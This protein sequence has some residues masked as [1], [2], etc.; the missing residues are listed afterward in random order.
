MAARQ[1][2][3]NQVIAKQENVSLIKSLIYKVGPIS[4]AEISEQL[5][6]TPPTI[7]NI[8]AEMIRDGI[9]QELE[10]EKKAP[11]GHA[12]R[13]PIRIDFIPDSRLAL[14]ISLGRDYTHYCISDLRGN[15]IVK[16]EDPMMPSEYEEMT[17][18]LIALIRRILKKYPDYREKLTGIGIAVPGIV[19]AH[20]GT[21]NKTDEE[22]RSWENQSL[23]DLVFREFGMPVRVENNVRARTL[24]LAL[25]RPQVLEDYET[26][27]LCYASWG[28][29]GPMILQN[30]SVRGEYGAAGEIGHIVMNPET[31]ETLEQYASLRCI[32]DKCRAAMK[33]GKIPVLSSLCRDPETLDIET[34]NEAQKQ[35][36]P[37]VKDLM[38]TAMKYLGIALS[39]IISFMNPDLIVLSGPMFLEE[40]N[41]TLC[42][43]IMR[44]HAYS[45]DIDHTVVRYV[46]FNEYSGAAAAA[47]ACLDKYFVR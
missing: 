13:N 17:K 25:F 41:R 33:E 21:I 45:A 8:V 39:N 42:E 16:G 14:G 2:G 15:M 4:R 40:D 29:A 35:G 18:K 10:T 44:K 28:I 43:Q 20:T 6:L 31:S 34:V 11:K 1:F 3:K 22:R 38:E 27:V 7:T 30:R 24:D 23:G 26:F 32:L 12:G 46:E 47:A 5:G 19:D 9:V 36:D 37:F